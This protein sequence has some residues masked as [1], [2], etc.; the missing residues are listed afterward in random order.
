MKNCLFAPPNRNSI[1]LSIFRV[2]WYHFINDMINK[3][4]VLLEFIDEAAVSQQIGRKYG[5]L[6][7]ALLLLIE[8]K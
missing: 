4:N 1:G 8:L 3:D 2:A 7:A 5:E 6:I